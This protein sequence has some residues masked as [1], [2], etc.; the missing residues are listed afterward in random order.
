MEVHPVCASKK[1][2]ISH[3]LDRM[4]GVTH[5]TAC[6]MSHRIREVIWEYGPGIL[7]GN[8][9]TVAADETY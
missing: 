8:G 6:V 4:L 1:S 2:M 7:G 5:K 3:Q 9:K